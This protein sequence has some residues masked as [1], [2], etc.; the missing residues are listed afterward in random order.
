MQLGERKLD[1]NIHGV[2]VCFFYQQQLVSTD[3]F[4]CSFGTA[5]AASAAESETTISFTKA[6][7]HTPIK[8]GN[9]DFSLTFL[10]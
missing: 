8:L 7:N 1:P 5:A 2:C 4:P 10:V 6:D 9:K 3:N